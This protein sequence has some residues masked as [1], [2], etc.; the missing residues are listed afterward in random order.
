MPVQYTLLTLIIPDAHI[1]SSSGPNNGSV[2][3][4]GTVLQRFIRKIIFFE[5]EEGRRII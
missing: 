4:L 1:F 5:H 2:L 3:L